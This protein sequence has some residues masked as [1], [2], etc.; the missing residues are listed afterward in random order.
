MKVYTNKFTDNFYL[1][2]VNTSSRDELPY[3]ITVN[4]TY[5]LLSIENTVGPGPKND[6]YITVPKVPSNPISQGTLY[7][8]KRQS[9]EY[10]L[11]I[12]SPNPIFKVYE[13]GK[14]F[15]IFYSDGS[16][17]SVYVD[18]MDYNGEFPNFLI[19][20]SSLKKLLPPGSSLPTVGSPVLLNR[21][22]SI[23]TE[24]QT[25][26]FLKVSTNTT[27][28][29]TQT[30]SVTLT[31]LQTIVQSQ[32]YEF[33][34]DP[35]ESPVKIIEQPPSGLREVQTSQ[36][37]RSFVPM[38]SVVT[39]QLDSSGELYMDKI[40]SG[41]S[42]TQNGYRRRCTNLGFEKDL[43]RFCSSIPKPA[44]YSLSEE[45]IKSSTPN[46]S[47]QYFTDINAGVSINKETQEG[48][49]IFAPLW[50]KDRVP[51][52]FAIF[53]KP[54]TYEGDNLLQEAS[55]VKLID[56]GASELG[57]YLNRLTSN[58]NFSRPP[59]ELSINN[60]YQIKWNGVSVDTGYWVS[61]TE[62]MGIEVQNGISDFEFNQMLS[63][64]FSRGSIVNP[65][66][67]NIEFLFDD[68]EAGL[69][70]V[71]QYFGLYC[72]DFEMSR[73]IPNVDSTS[74]LF[75]QNETRTSSNK[76]FNSS[77]ISNP[78]GVKLVVDLNDVPDRNLIVKDPHT[79]LVD[80][81]VVS[82]NYK[83][84]ILP[85]NQV[86]R[87]LKISFTS[88]SDISSLFSNGKLVRLDD[89]NGEFV[90]YITVS[91]S[92][93]DSTTKQMQVNFVE[94]DEYSTLGLSYSINIF[95]VSPDL[96]PSV[97]GRMRF[98]SPRIELSRCVSISKKDLQGNEI[99]NWLNSVLNADTD[100][101]DT[102]VFFD[103]SSS[104]YCIVVPNSTKE[105]QDYIKVFF[106]VME[107]NGRFFDGDEVFLNVSDYQISGILPGPKIVNSETRKFVLKSKG[108][109]HS[110]KSFELFN[111]KNAVVGLVSLDST[112]YNLGS[113]IGTSSTES[114]PVRVQTSP[115][116]G[117]SLT[118]SSV[119]ND[120]ISPGDSITVEKFV[121]G[122]KR[123]W[124]VIRSSSREI[125]V[126]RTSG[127]VTELEIVDG[128]LVSN[129]GY[130]RL[131]VPSQSYFPVKF[132][133]FK[134]VNSESQQSDV[135]LEFISAE[136]Q[137][138]GNYLLTF[139]NKNVH[140]DYLTVR[141]NSPETTFTYFD[142][143]PS[144]SLETVLAVAF[145][146][147]VDCP[148]RAIVGN[149]SLYLYSDVGES[150]ISIGLY[151]S[152]GTI[153]QTKING[154][155]LKSAS[156]IVDSIAM[157]SDYYVYDVDPVKNNEIYSI[158]P[159]F[160][161]R[162]TSDIK[163]L[164]KSGAPANVLQWN[165]LS[166][167]IPDVRSMVD[168]SEDRLLIKFEGKN[169][170]SL[171]NDRLQLIDINTVSLSALSF[172]EMIDLDFF[173]EI[174]SRVGADIGNSQ[175]FFFSPESSL[176]SRKTKTANSVN[177]ATVEGGKKTLSLSVNIAENIYS[178][179][180]NWDPSNN[181]DFLAFGT[182]RGCSVT[183]D[184]LPTSWN[185]SYGF[186]IQYLDKTGNWIDY[187]LDYPTVTLKASEVLNYSVSG[188]RDPMWDIEFD[189]S[190]PAQFNSFFDV[191]QVMNTIV[192]YMY[193]SS[194]SERLRG[195]SEIKRLVSYCFGELSSENVT[196]EDQIATYVYKVVLGI[197]EEHLDYRY[198]CSFPEGTY[199]VKN[200]TVIDVVG[201]KP[202]EDKKITG[203]PDENIISN[204]SAS[205]DSTEGKIRTGVGRWKRTNTSN[206]DLSPYLINVDPLLLPYDM[207]VNAK[208]SGNSTIAFSLDWY[209]ISGWPKFY[210]LDNVSTN[211]QYT[212]KR[213]NVDELK[214]TVYDYFTEY[215][216]VG[217]GE[218]TFANG[219]QRQ[220]KFLWSFIESGPNGY[221]T[222]FKGMPLTFSSS[223]IN[224]E[225][226]RFVAVLQVET[227]L[228]VPM[229]TSLIYNQTWNCMTLLVQINVD[230]Y[231]VDGSISLEQLYQLR[232][233]TAKTDESTLYGPML[234]YGQDVL[235]FDKVDRAYNER[236]VV[237]TNEPIE[238]EN[239]YEYNQY[240]YDTRIDI[241]YDDSSKDIEIF[242][243]RYYPNVDYVINGVVFSGTRYQ[244]EIN[245]VVP[246]SRIRGV[247]DPQL[248]RDKLFIDGLYND[249]FFAVLSDVDGA[250]LSTYATFVSR[251][252]IKIDGAFTVSN[253]YYPSSE[254]LTFD[255]TTFIAS[256]KVYAIGDW[257]VYEDLIDEISA[258]SMLN[259]LSNSMFND[260]FVSID[261]TESSTN[262][263]I[264]YSSPN[265]IRPIKTKNASVDDFGNVTV[266]EKESNTNIFR[267]DGGF[268][269]SYKRITSFSACEEIS[270]T[271]QLLNSLR[272]YNTKLIGVNP[273]SL[274]Y[275]RVSE[276]GVNSGNINVN[277]AVLN[278]PY[279]I[280]R[281]QVSP[282]L[283]VWGEGFY[284]FAEDNFIDSPV[285]GITD[286]KD[287]KFFL[288]S[289]VMS[290]PSFFRTSNYSV[291]EVIEGTDA[292]NSSVTYVSGNTRLSVQIDLEGIVSDY[293]FNS[294]VF[295]FFSDTW[296]ELNTT[297]SP[298]QISKE[299]IDRNLLNRYS[300][301]SI[302]VYQRPYSRTEI[303]SSELPPEQQGFEFVNTIGIQAMR[304][305]DFSI[306]IDG[307]KQVML[308]FNIKRR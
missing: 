206:V 264:T 262:I 234:V 164:S 281:K 112:T 84:T 7:A 233:N 76:D 99:I 207:F 236:E 267:L 299:Y 219:A 28:K 50:I 118:F 290:V 90:A 75:R 213:I 229:R 176:F 191:Q 18:L 251:N 31:A 131:E 96:S 1:P 292:K 69:Y 210:P 97:F 162:L 277:G 140:T 245:L 227:E 98:D 194:F 253:T 81:Q 232:V 252:T 239:Y 188:Q 82:S 117:A 144:D 27:A 193:T 36:L 33:I 197:D 187:R 186:K 183:S 155:S 200:E 56:I 174:P 246:R 121:G 104:A 293:L 26:N 241:K 88:D 32:A 110:V 254:N 158:E 271:R 41:S 17:S 126:Y 300:V 127:A 286:P 120:T 308:A 72:D 296:D 189:K 147:F 249:D 180:K 85:T 240:R 133:E 83:V 231:F 265:V 62:F 204:F 60:G 152:S 77:V 135:E 289:K 21:P 71:Y 143:G 175:A 19:E 106:S 108:E 307:S 5:G 55:L 6:I 145:Q 150:D 250:P 172:Y 45:D 93:Y 40:E 10:Y 226:T 160:I 270:I 156:V 113:I 42:T 224:I 283:N 89:Q 305:F 272:G 167:G 216:T 4:D 130:T 280:G 209:L 114:I 35:V 73:F 138:N 63:G 103:K 157:F 182:P 59:L 288:S 92:S 211:Y 132:D 244:T 266:L 184:T 16:Y 115:Y 12:T 285:Q 48:F 166:Y 258:Y 275:R 297:I 148:F 225:S 269:P 51:S 80:S 2:L 129:D 202:D 128:T 192:L 201:G 190:T 136:N 222:T 116:S 30:A 29:G 171:L 20:E 263:S 39:L 177:N 279:A 243:V 95:D 79:I 163:I 212:G 43:S 173:D 261:G 223:K 151:L 23:S 38:S 268:E 102:M 57:P 109:A 74:A 287:Q 301:E 220:G 37:A 125:G 238:T 47:E 146:R 169:Q 199:T 70:D 66:L 304:F 154:S 46:L 302:D 237:I 165:N 25:R 291:S 78:D 8:K 100:V 303:V 11:E 214:S 284:S 273:T 52:Y 24:F 179:W 195:F 221:A 255:G 49:R 65:Q 185:P 3:S 58:E 94:N 218:E 91:G 260:V 53:R 215:F 22:Y 198:V 276:Q 181:P 142:Y 248:G 141:V 137:D 149:G 282:L 228:D 105:E 34:I 68:N 139:S 14:R 86:S 203:V 257:P 61:H 87:K 134:L 196:F 9:G 123:R 161:S 294:G 13:N 178:D 205:I 111:Y 306:P 159:Q 247:F 274:W 298:Y 15:Y 44:L 235:Q 124:S 230:S 122:F 54:A 101:R 295:A 259:R 119:N 170:P 64:G 217:N 208:E 107:S 242:G 153:T 278:V 168:D 67:L 256:A